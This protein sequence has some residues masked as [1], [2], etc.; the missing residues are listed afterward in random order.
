MDDEGLT[1]RNNTNSESIETNDIA[2]THR[3]GPVGWFFDRP[4]LIWVFFLYFLYSTVFDLSRHYGNWVGNF[5][6]EKQAHYLNFTWV[7]WTATCLL[8]GV[9]LAGTISLVL[10]KRVAATLFVSV[11]FINIIILGYQMLLG[12]GTGIAGTNLTSLV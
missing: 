11:L 5:G 12:T 2:D 7:D 9:T 8:A 4:A 10:L 3:K 1:E 6:P